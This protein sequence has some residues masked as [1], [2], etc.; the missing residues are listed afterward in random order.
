MAG[1]PRARAN[2][3]NNNDLMNNEEIINEHVTLLRLIPL[4]GDEISSLQWLAKHRLI[5]NAVVCMHCNEAATLNAFAQ[6]Q[7][8]WRWRC[9]RDNF[10]QSVRHKSFFSNS[11]L[12]LKHLILLLYFWAYDTPQTIIMHELSIGDWHTVVDWINFIREVCEQFLEDNP[13]ELGGID[14][15]GY[16]IIV[17]I[18]ETKYFH[19]K[20]QRGLWKEGH[21]VFGA[22]ERDSGRCLMQEVADRK[23]ETL[24]PII[25]RWILPGSRIV[26]DGW[27]AYGTLA[28]INGGVYAHDIIVHERHFVD[29]D[30]PNIHTQTIESTWMRAKRKLRRQHGTSRE[31]F[32]SY[33]CE[34]LW[35]NRVHEKHFGNI[36][37]AIH[38]M[39]DV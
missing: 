21:W 25:S 6:G 35:R 10:T 15:D 31:L 23:A 16:P 22:I 3:V 26:S 19:R 18:D 29:P 32:P 38:S 27:R 36:L 8:K 4:L 12:S 9:N 33:L 14:E 39:Y 34:F 30:N 7:D 17:E 1:R 37:I 11:H 20:Y 2:I 24:N 28:N 13:I 5:T